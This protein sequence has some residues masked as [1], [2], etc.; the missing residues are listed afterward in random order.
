MD[1]T[2]LEHFSTSDIIIA[3]KFCIALLNNLLHNNIVGR[4]SIKS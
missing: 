4:M 3:Y 1:M 2:R